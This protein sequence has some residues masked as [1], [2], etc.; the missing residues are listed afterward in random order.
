MSLQVTKYEIQDDLG[1]GVKDRL[2]VQFGQEFVESWSGTRLLSKLEVQEESRRQGHGYS[3]LV[4][5]DKTEKRFIVSVPCS[6]VPGLKLAK[7]VGLAPVLVHWAEDVHSP[8]VPSLL[9]PQVLFVGGSMVSA[10]PSEIQPLVEDFRSSLCL[11]CSSTLSPV[12]TRSIALMLR[13]VDAWWIRHRVSRLSLCVTAEALAMYLSH[14]DLERLSYY[15]SPGCHVSL[16]ADIWPVV[17]HFA[18]RAIMLGSPQVNELQLSPFQK[19]A[20]IGVGLQHKKFSVVA[21]EYDIP[22]DQVRIHF[23]LGLK[24]VRDYIMALSSAEISKEIEQKVAEARADVLKGTERG[25]VA[26]ELIDV[27]NDAV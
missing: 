13:C 10:A 3:L 25:T 18:L 20:L 16:V 7:A 24:R 4:Q 15:I 11:L 8:Q 17:S 9:V 22:V 14:Q 26:D 21:H 23:K 12:A 1:E 27:M 2:K 5:L 19:A 6:S